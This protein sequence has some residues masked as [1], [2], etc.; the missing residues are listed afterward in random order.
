MGSKISTSIVNIMAH[1]ITADNAEVGM[2]AKCGVRNAQA[3]RIMRAVTQ[4]ANGDLT[5]DAA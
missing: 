1:I 3:Q 4:P 5:P 2:Y